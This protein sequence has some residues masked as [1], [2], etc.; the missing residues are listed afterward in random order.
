MNKVKEYQIFLKGEDSTSSVS[1]FERI[2]NKFKVVFNSGKAFTYNSSNVKIIESVL[3]QQKPRSVFDY[4][5][6][7]SEKV[8]IKAKFGDGKE[9]NVLSYNYSK[10]DFIAKDSLLGHFLSE[11][12]QFTGERLNDTQEIYPFGFNSSQKKP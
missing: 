10:L 1:K 7:I 6:N 2:G 12:K 9:F 8:G 4:L 5:R 11:N 3:K